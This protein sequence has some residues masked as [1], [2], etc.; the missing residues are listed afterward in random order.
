[1]KL[2]LD[3]FTRG[4]LEA[5]LFSETDNADESGGEPLD[6]NYSLNDF[7]PEAIEKAKADC[8]DFQTAQ[9]E[10]LTESEIDSHKAGCCFWWNRNGHGTGFWDQGNSNELVFRKLSDASK[11]YG[12]VNAMVDDGKISLH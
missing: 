7:T 1:M 8:A 12:T 5:C 6:R 9:A 4:Y 2:E 3:S 10:L 11:V